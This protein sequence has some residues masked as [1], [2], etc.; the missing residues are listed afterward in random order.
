MSAWDI[1]LRSV[2]RLLSSTFDFEQD[3]NVS[4]IWGTFDE[5]VLEKEILVNETVV[6]DATGASAAAAWTSFLQPS[7]SEWAE[8]WEY[9]PSLSERPVHS[10]P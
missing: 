2:T 1:T 4:M 5:N 8:A 6:G 9:Q 7:P 10:L 3:P